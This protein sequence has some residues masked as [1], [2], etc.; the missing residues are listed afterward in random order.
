MMPSAALNFRRVISV[1]A[2]T[3]YLSLPI[4]IGIKGGVIDGFLPAL[5]WPMP[6]LVAI[7]GLGS[8]PLWAGALLGDIGFAAVWIAQAA[9]VIAVGVLRKREWRSAKHAIGTAWGIIAAINVVLW[10]MLG[11]HFD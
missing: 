3:I 4:F 1:L 2:I 6:V 8:I 10:I 7:V 5:V 11:P 9:L